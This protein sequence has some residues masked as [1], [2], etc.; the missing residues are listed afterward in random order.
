M[1]CELAPMRKVTVGTFRGSVMVGIREFYEKDG[2]TL[3]GRKGISLGKEQWDAVCN[4]KDAIDK[5]C[6]A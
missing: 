1:V 2:K 6:E 5:A 3:P 4:S